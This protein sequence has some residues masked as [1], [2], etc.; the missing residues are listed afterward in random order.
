MP[1]ETKQSFEGTSAMLYT[2]SIFIVVVGLTYAAVPLY[3]MFCQATG[4]GGTVRTDRSLISAEK[5]TP[6]RTG[7]RIRISFNAD[8][9]T[10]MQWKFA[11][12][13][14]EV[15]VYPGET[16]L[17]FYTAENTTDQDIIGI[18]TYNVCPY[19]SG[20]YFNKIQCFCFEEQK[21]KAGERVDMPIFFFI[22]PEFDQDP[23]MDDIRE[24]TLSYTFFNARQGVAYY[25]PPAAVQ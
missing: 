3:R 9:A 5:M 23:M 6:N 12:Q 19:K 17:A 25:P 20:A 21:L 24:I 8:T 11:P 13:Q 4:L 2:G 16:A 7:R 1:Q 18:S 22:D 10:S 14:S 15:F